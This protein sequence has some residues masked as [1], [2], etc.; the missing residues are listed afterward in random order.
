VIEALQARAAPAERIQ[1]L[2]G[3]LATGEA[4]RELLARVDLLH[5]SGHAH[6]DSSRGWGSA[7]DLAGGGELSVGDILTLECVPCMVVLSGCETARTTGQSPIEGIAL[8]HAFILRGATQ[9]IATTRPVDD[10][11]ALQVAA[12]LYRGPTRLDDAAGLLRQA[13]LEALGTGISVDWASYRV[14]EP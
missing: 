3:D 6:F 11:T 4:I 12:R 5:Y 8:S 1:T 9:V 7:M 13:Q 14:I 10:Q 2:V